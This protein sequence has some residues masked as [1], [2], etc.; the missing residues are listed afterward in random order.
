MSHV[1]ALND[2]W[3]AATSFPTVAGEQVWVSDISGAPPNSACDVRN[4]VELVNVGPLYPNDGVLPPRTSRTP[5][6]VIHSGGVTPRG[7]FAGLQMSLHI[8]EW[9]QG[10][11][12]RGYWDDARAAVE[13]FGPRPGFS[14]QRV[15]VVR[16][17]DARRRGDGGAASALR[18]RRRRLD[19]SGP[20]PVADA[21]R[22]RL[23]DAVP[24]RVD[25]QDA[26]RGRRRRGAGLASAS[27]RR[28]RRRVLVVGAAAGTAR[29]HRGALRA[30]L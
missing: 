21:R 28:G 19:S 15:R 14:P 17:R 4:G 20:I 25:G 26:R 16:R 1:E 11:K 7:G 29:E 13:H 27:R 9:W 24:R 18:G 30:G 3:G 5:D 10:L 12:Y 8:G 2:D 22:R 23:H 6:G